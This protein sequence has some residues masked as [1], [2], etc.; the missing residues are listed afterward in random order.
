MRKKYFYIFL[1][2]IFVSSCGGTSWKK[3]TSQEG[4]F[5]VWMPGTPKLTTE[6]I[7]T[8]AGKLNLY[9]HEVSAG[10]MF[11]IVAYIDY[12]EELIKQRNPY[13]MLEDGRDGAINNVQGK[14]LNEA[15]VPYLGH[16]GKE[17][18]A[19]ATREKV[20]YILKMKFF[21][22]KNRLYQLGVV[23]YKDKETATQSDVKKFYNSFSL[24][25]N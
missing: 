17:I 13:K 8:A 1:F 11:Y 21:L 10:N 22:I 12:P 24:L 20:P 19:E 14:L 15:D 6:A 5:S 7:D 18:T 9:S 25:T 4:N 3:F 23:M 16:P 2:L